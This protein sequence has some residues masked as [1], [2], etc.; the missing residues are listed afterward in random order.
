MPYR[1]LGTAY[2]DE[3][4]RHRV[5]QRPVRRLAHLGDLVNV[6]RAA[7]TPLFSG[8][9]QSMAGRRLLTRS[10]HDRL[11]KPVAVAEVVVRMVEGRRRFQ[12][13]RREHFHAI[14]L[15][16]E[17]LVLGPGTVPIRGVAREQ[18]DDCVELRTRELPY[19]VVGVIRAGVA[20]DLRAGR[21]A[22][23]ELVG[24]RGK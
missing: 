3:R 7:Y 24:K 20:E 18:N 2:C 4:E 13:Q 14:Q 9:Y 23:P 22:L 17:S 19:P 5:A 8:A 11:R 15:R 1:A 10:F 6:Q 12:V 16:D 21:H